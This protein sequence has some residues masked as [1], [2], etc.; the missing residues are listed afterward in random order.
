[1]SFYQIIK[2]VL[3]ILNK[4]EQIF[5]TVRLSTSQK[6]NSKERGARERCSKEGFH[7]RTDFRDH[8]KTT[9][10]KLPL[11]LQPFDLFQRQKEICKTSRKSTK[12]CH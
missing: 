11:E 2:S 3:L 5:L 10:C 9:Q 1:L 4:I 12:I 7:G 6:R 8:E